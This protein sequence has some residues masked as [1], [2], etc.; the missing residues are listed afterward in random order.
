MSANAASSL[1]HLATVCIEKHLPSLYVVLR[2][3]SL[4]LHH[5]RWYECQPIPHSRDLILSCT[6]QGDNAYQIHLSTREGNWLR[7]TL[8]A[9]GDFQLTNPVHSVGCR[10]AADDSSVK[11][12]FACEGE[13]IIHNRWSKRRLSPDHFIPMAFPTSGESQ[14]CA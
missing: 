9:F 13:A 14:K 6:L 7:H 11:N 4:G 2:A 3:K 12:T 10:T 8:R 1:A 5:R